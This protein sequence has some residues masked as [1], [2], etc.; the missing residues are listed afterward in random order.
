VASNQYR[1][2][3]ACVKSV[4]ESRLKETSGSREPGV[5]STCDLEIVTNQLRD[6]TS[7]G[8]RPE[9][10]DSLH[11]RATKTASLPLEMGPH[12]AFFLAPLGGSPWRS[13]RILIG[14]GL[15]DSGRLQA[16]L[17]DRGDSP[18][19]FPSHPANPEGC[20][21]D[22]NDDQDWL[23]NHRADRADSPSSFLP[24]LANR[25]DYCRDRMRTPRCRSS[26]KL[27]RPRTSL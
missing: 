9:G 22:P 4:R 16:R 3:R 1:G 17:L 2:R 24:R 11:P 20:G 19:S 21:L 10:G 8:R 6:C 23:R 18:N 7:G 5:R 27:P 12:R 15:D 26:R 14:N 25:A 13:W